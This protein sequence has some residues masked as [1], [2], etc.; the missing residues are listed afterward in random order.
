MTRILLAEDNV[1][2]AKL[3][4]FALESRGFSVQVAYDGRVA[5]EFALQEVF[6]V[7]ITDYDMPE[8][9]GADFFQQLRADRRY[10]QTPIIM[11]S[12]YCSH[13]DLAKLND[14]RRLSAFVSKPCKPAD[15]IKMIEGLAECHA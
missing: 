11:L 4:C 7:V 10:D 5:S 1:T 2:F 8:M 6:D 3:L 14:E 9:N 12:A 13:L 15:L